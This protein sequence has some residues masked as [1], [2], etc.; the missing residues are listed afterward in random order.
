MKS[1]PLRPFVLCSLLASLAVVFASCDSLDYEPKGALSDGQ[2]TSDDRVEKLVN[3]AYASLGNDHWL[4][5]YS[6]MWAYGGVR[7]DNAY[8]GGGGTADQGGY[9]RYEQFAFV[10]TDQEKANDMWERLYIGVS[11]ANR[12]L[13]RIDG[14]SEEEYPQKTTRAAEMRFVRGHFHFLLKQLFK[15]VPYI[16][17]S[18]PSDSLENVSNREYSS[19]ELWDQIAEDFRFAAENL[20]ATQS[21]PGRADGTAAQAYL[22]KTLLFSAYEKNEQHQVMDIDQEELQEVV[23]LVDEIESSGEYDLYGE[24]GKNFL[25]PYE[26]GREAIFSVQ[27]S[28]NDGT[29]QGR[30]AMV[31]G[32]NYPM[33]GGYGCCW[34][35]IP[36]QNL[37]NAF[38]TGDDGLP[39]YDS[40]NEGNLTEPQDFQNN[41]FDPRLDHTVAV[42]QHPFK[43]QEDVTYDVSSW[44]RVP[45]I[46]GPF[47]SMKALQRSDCSCFT[48]VGPFFASSNN[49]TI[50]RYA[51]VLLWKAEAL[52]EM[53][54]QDEALPIINR[55]RE[56]AANVTDR[57]RYDDG[58]T[59]SNYEIAT[60]EPGENINWTQ[61]NARR[62]L[63]W[64][65]R[66]ELATEGQRFFD[67]VRWGIAAETLNP[68]FEVESQRHDY[69]ET[70]EFTEGQD[71]YLPIPQQQIDF[72]EGLY[73][74]NTGW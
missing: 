11:R 55:I 68:Y 22:A 31:N 17:E 67:L 5:P 16:D 18:I 74:Q 24:Y 26:N 7:S 52:I 32:L 63:R 36:S 58:S 28:I 33:G 9:N 14:L 61:E 73:V 20:P 1:S 69:L 44:T 25:F 47:T 54:Q 29:T 30:V 53:G 72:S 46:Y 13:Q 45:Q 66:M 12:A 4:V 49:T 21:E 71:E 37:V 8:K 40:F 38:Q 64:E 41:T 59:Y 34:F 57:L 65:R 39:L 6:N 60:Y 56:R 43:Y 70:A 27:R 23:D 2:F 15:R 35:Y 10:T 42:P 19:Q 48:S 50:I 51:D 3:A 62:A